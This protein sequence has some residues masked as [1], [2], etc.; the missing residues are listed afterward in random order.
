MVFKG[1]NFRVARLA[2]QGL[3]EEHRHD[4]N[5]EQIDG[6]IKPRKEHGYLQIDENTTLRPA[7]D[8][9]SETMW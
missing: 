2:V 9:V 4:I 8:T 7:R 6:I 3:H 1:I 5:V